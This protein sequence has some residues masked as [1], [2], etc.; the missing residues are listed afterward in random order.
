[1]VFRLIVLRPRW[2]IA[3]LLALTLIAAATVS[4][5]KPPPAGADEHVYHP[6]GK[7]YRRTPQ[8]I[9]GQK[10]DPRFDLVN[11]TYRTVAEAAQIYA[12]F[13]GAEVRVPR[14][15]AARPLGSGIQSEG[16]MGGNVAYGYVTWSLDS[17]LPYEGVAVVKLGRGVVAF[18]AA[19][20]PQ[21]AKQRRQAT[22]TEIARY[23]DSLSEERFWQLIDD[24]RQQG[25]A[26]CLRTAEA[27]KRSLARLS[28]D[29]VLGF[30][31]RFQLMMTASYRYDLWAV[32]YI[33]NGG[34]SDDG[35]T[36][37]RAWLVGQ[38]RER[39]ESALKHPPAAVE[40]L[41]KPSPIMGFDCEQLLYPSMEVYQKKTGRLPPYGLVSY[42]PEPAGKPWQEED[43][44]KLYPELYRRFR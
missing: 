2:L 11:V 35:F 4:G 21:Q 42:P 22:E 32:A 5:C 14:D 17:H 12:D 25:R 36:Y 28:E 8:V 16:T 30:E 13:S 27:L 41:T 20:P 44:P 23:R 7:T 39:F 9:P 10:P 19:E 15:L 31:L 26:D 1:M 24:A 43:L 3:A 33:A 6:S 34:A 38:G 40:G 37:F 29:E 18:R